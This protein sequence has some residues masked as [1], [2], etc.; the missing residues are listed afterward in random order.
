[1]GERAW[2][3]LG[4][5]PSPR[6]KASA[7]YDVKGDRLLV[8]G[9]DANDLWAQKLSGPSAGQWQR[10]EAGGDLPPPGEVVMTID[11]KTQ[12][13]FVFS[14]RALDRAWV[15]PLSGHGEWKVLGFTNAPN[16][17]LGFSLATDDSG[18]RLFA[19]TSGQPEMWEIPLDD[20]IAWTRL[21]GSPQNGGF[22]C[23]DT[24]VYDGAHAQMLVLSGG[25][26]RGN[27]FALSL[28]GTP[29]WSKRNKDMA[30]FDYGAMMLFDAGA[31][32]FL[33]MDPSQ[34]GW[35]WSF[36]VDDAAPKWAHLPIEESDHGRRWEAA[37]V[38]DA[39]HQRALLF[40]GI[41]NTTQSL[42]DDTWALSLGDAP[43]WTQVGKVDRRL[44]VGFG[45]GLA[46]AG[47]T[48]TIVRFGGLNQGVDSSSMRFDG[49]TGS[50]DGLGD[51]PMVIAGWSAGAWDPLGH[52]LLNF[53]GYSNLPQNET[54]ALDLA[55]SAWS[56]VASKG[57]R[58]TARARHSMVLDPSGKQMLVFGGVQQDSIGNQT[59]ASD[60]WSLSLTDDG[61]TQ[62]DAGP[63][64]SPRQSHAAAF[65]EAGRRMLVHGGS[66]SAVML[67]DTWML[68]MTPSPHWVSLSP[69]GS[70]PPALGEQYAV[71]D[72]DTR[73]FL[74]VANVTPTA[75]SPVPAVGVWALSTEG[76]ARWQHF[77]ASGTRPAKVDG[78]LWTERGLFVTAGGSAWIF[79]ASS[80]LCD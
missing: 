49:K 13:L 47:D 28:E 29:T 4:D 75:E 23:R 63:G 36:S 22:S 14:S 20:G 42:R 8:F 34:T 55:S 32:R 78:A 74:L 53:G 46:E 70:A 37:S 41:D 17:S 79:D 3:L 43:S 62:L 67:D 35:I 54:T 56:E 16:I 2:T 69:E 30:W 51:T 80:P 76:K 38:Y 21:A 58:P 39:K 12:R 57:P 60:L 6:E 18:R 71:Y 25:W 31:R 27:V 45:A 10:I 40:G 50:W 61:W 48:G 44:P 26:P 59:P 65:D 73:R 9:G 72:P 66:D 7:L 11:E 1:V 68:E 64:P 15:L 77:C 52:R 5:A 19:Y 24:L 33:V